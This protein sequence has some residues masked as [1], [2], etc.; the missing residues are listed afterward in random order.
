[1]GPFR[2]RNRTPAIAATI[3]QTIPKWR[4]TRLEFYLDGV[5]R[6]TFTCEPPGDRLVYLSGRLSY[7]GYTVRI[8]AGDEDGNT[9][10]ESWSFE[11]LGRG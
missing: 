11:A 3:W 5:E 8:N 6:T 9:T 7:S 10:T 1:L 2:T 4:R